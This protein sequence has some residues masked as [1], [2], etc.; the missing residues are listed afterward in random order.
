MISREDLRLV[1]GGLRGARGMVSVSKATLEQLIAMARL[2]HELTGILQA[3]KDSADAGEN[4]LAAARRLYVGFRDSS[5][6][7]V[8]R[9]DLEIERLVREAQELKAALMGYASAWD[10]G[11]EARRALKL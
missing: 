9:S 3:F 4:V 7:G 5:K 10:G 11:L 1:E 8:P 6:R 2:A